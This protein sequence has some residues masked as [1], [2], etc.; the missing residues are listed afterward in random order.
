[1]HPLLETPFAL[2]A[3][4]VAKTKTSP[5]LSTGMVSP[6]GRGLLGRGLCKLP[7]E[8]FSDIHQAWRS[9]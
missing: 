4:L 6:D 1:M 9:S 8:P 3:A 2:D 5:L 7:L